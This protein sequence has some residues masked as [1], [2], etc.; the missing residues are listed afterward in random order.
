MEKAVQLS[1]KI[2][3]EVNEYSKAYT[4]TEGKIATT[5][6]SLAILNAIIQDVCVLYKYVVDKKL[7]E[8]MQRIIPTLNTLADLIMKIQITKE[9]ANKLHLDSANQLWQQIKAVG[10]L[11]ACMIVEQDEANKQG[12]K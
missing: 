6:Q 2:I 3:Y 5:E 11:L 8:D 7:Y 9:N 10:A 12:V 4:S 1:E